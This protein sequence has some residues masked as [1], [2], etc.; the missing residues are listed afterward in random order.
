MNFYTLALIHCVTVKHSQAGGKYSVEG[1]RASVSGGDASKRFVKKRATVNNLASQIVKGHGC[2]VRCKSVKS[3][4]SPRAAIR[5]P[6]ASTCNFLRYGDS[7]TRTFYFIAFFSIFSVFVFSDFYLL[8]LSRLD[9][10]RQAGFECIKAV[11]CAE[12]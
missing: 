1:L 12:I 5:G 2:R 6:D 9:W 7:L 4:W 3:P 11:S 10:Q 8:Y